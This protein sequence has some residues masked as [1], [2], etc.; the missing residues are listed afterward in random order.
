MK[1]TYL[2]RRAQTQMLH[3][4]LCRPCRAPRASN[5][6]R[7]GPNSSGKAVVSRSTMAR[8]PISRT[9]ASSAACRVAAVPQAT[10]AFAVLSSSLDSRS[11]GR[12]SRMEVPSSSADVRQLY[13]S[14]PSAQ[15]NYNLHHAGFRLIA[16]TTR[17][18]VHD[19]D[20][21]TP[22]QVEGA[23]AIQLTVQHWQ[24]QHITLRV[25]ILSSKCRVDVNEA[26][27]AHRSIL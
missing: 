19:H 9:A 10:S 12:L 16:L 23:R 15:N 24:A 20:V 8:R 17:V 2:R 7:A 18:D 1:C 6:L 26:T 5:A 22:A 13:G 25:R 11:G 3:H 27:L 4:T 21:L 14:I